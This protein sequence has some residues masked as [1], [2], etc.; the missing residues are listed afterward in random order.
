MTYQDY[1]RNSDFEDI[2]IILSGFY[3]E[4]EAL[5]SR[6]CSLVEALKSLPADSAHST[7]PIEMC[8]GYDN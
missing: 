2:W 1:F 6:Y 8:L 4:H 5:K 7:T 3:M